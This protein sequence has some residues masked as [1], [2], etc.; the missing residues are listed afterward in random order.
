MRPYYSAAGDVATTSGR[1]RR[2]VIA[3]TTAI[4]DA[5]RAHDGVALSLEE[6]P[7]RHVPLIGGSGA[8]MP[9]RSGQR[10]IGI[11]HAGHDGALARSSAELTSHPE[12]CGL[13]ELAATPL[14]RATDPFR[15]PLLFHLTILPLCQPSRELHPSA[16]LSSSTE[17]PIPTPR[18]ASFTSLFYLRSAFCLANPLAAVSLPSFIPGTPPAPRAVGIPAAGE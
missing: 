3:T 5:L 13:T 10:A 18:G 8:R 14:A 11:D 16:C 4:R 15:P 2:D 12:N 6:F 9:P 17:H 7:P 1:R